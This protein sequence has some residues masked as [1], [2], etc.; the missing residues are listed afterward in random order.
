ML[1][2]RYLCRSIIYKR[3]YRTV[4]LAPSRFVL[5]VRKLVV[6]ELFFQA[7]TNSI[8]NLFR[9]QRPLSRGSILHQ[10]LTT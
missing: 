5:K 8:F 10:G 9:V 4:R 7:E 6:G 3:I 2:A 1:L